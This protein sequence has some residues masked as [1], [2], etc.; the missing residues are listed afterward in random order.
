MDN[1]ERSVNQVTNKDWFA[2]SLSQYGSYKL[3]GNSHGGTTQL[4]Q[5]DQESISVLGETYI[6]LSLKRVQ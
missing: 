6:D 2:V 4:L 1:L 5:P 3:D